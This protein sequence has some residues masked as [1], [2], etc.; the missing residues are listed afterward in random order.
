MNNDAAAMTQALLERCTFPAAGTSLHCAVSGGADSSALLVL[1][2]AAGCVTTAHHVD[3]GLR[4]GSEAEAGVVAA[5]AERVGAQFVS[6]RCTVPAGPNLEARARAARFGVL[7]TN[8]AT[9]HTVEDRAET[10]LINLLRG[11]GRTGLSPLRDPNRHPIVQLR[12]SETVELCQALDIDV[13]VDPSNGDPA[14][15]RNRIRHELLPLLDDIS[16]RDVAALLDRQADVFGA[17]DEFLDEL[18]SHIDATDAKALATAPV[19][20]ARRA[21]RRFIMNSWSREHP[22]GVASVDRALEV[23]RGIATSCEIEGGHR[24][25]RTN[26][27]LRLEDPLGSVKNP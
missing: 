18:A 16:Q 20:L 2:A 7:P 11:A 27:K 19:V 24:V 8:V 15:V 21:M 6:H 22:P 1:A 14:F 23:A 25:H 5:L 17:E 9:G 10:M 3:H 4:P 13:V 12:R 26:Q